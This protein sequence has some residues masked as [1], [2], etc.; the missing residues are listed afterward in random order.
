MLDL[1]YTIIKSKKAGMF[2]M[3]SFIKGVVLGI[4]MGVG[5]VFYMKSKG[6]I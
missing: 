1:I 4:I 6:M 3:G 5:G 2:D